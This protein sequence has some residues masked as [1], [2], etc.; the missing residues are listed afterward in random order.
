MAG[1]G[2]VAVRARALAARPGASLLPRV[3]AAAAG[4]LV[5]AVASAD[6]PA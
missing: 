1:P 5:A 2:L 4:L 3:G 6:R